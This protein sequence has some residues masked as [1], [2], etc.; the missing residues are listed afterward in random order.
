MKASRVVATLIVVLA[1]GWIASGAVGGGSKAKVDPAAHK[2]AV[3]PARFRVAVVPAHVTP[4]ARRITL[5]GNTEADRRAPAAARIAGIVRELRVKR[6]DRVTAG[7]IV[8]VLSDDGRDAQVAQAKARLIQ[9]RIDLDAKRKLIAAGVVAAANQPGLEADYQA[10]DA[11][12]AAAQAEANKGQ[13]LAPIDGI[14]NE[15]SVELGQ[16]VGANA[17]VANVIAL[18]PMLAVVEIAEVHLAGIHVGDRALVHLVTGRTVEGKVRFISHRA[19][20]GT[21][22]YRV[23]V[24]V[25]NADGAIPD[26]ITCSVDLFLASAPAAKL[27]RSALTFSD[28]GEIGVRTVGANDRVA[29]VPVSVVEDGEQ[30]LWVAGVPDGARV[31]VQGQDFVKEGTVVEAVPAPAAR[32]AS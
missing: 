11:A 15:T 21:R 13:V 9:R 14:V 4:H 17:T 8:A 24:A 27:P 19:S 32:A 28:A 10:A 23:E 5:S 31:I 26:G 30:E 3:A 2:D 6:G 20:A 7:E 1:A 25:P 16:A 12:L 29:F 22:T 18:Q